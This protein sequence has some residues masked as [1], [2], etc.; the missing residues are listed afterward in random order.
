MSQIK[1]FL[2]IT[3]LVVGMAISGCGDKRDVTGFSADSGK[4]EANWLA[5]HWVDAQKNL[6]ACQECHGSNLLGGIATVS[7]FSA[8]RGAQVCHAGGPVGDNAG[9]GVGWKHQSRHGRQGAMAT[10]NQYSAGF[11]YCTKCHGADFVG[12]ADKATSCKSCHTKAPHPDKPWHGTTAGGTNHVFA[13]PKNADQCYLCHQNGNNSYLKP[14]APASAGTAPSCFNST[15]CHG[16]SAH[17]TQWTDPASS[18]FH[19]NTAAISSSCTLCH[20]VNYDGVGGT[21]PSCGNANSQTGLKCHSNGTP[22]N[23]KATDC[24]S[25][26][27]TPPNAAAFPNTQ[28]SHSAHNGLQGVTCNACH[29]GGGSGTANHAKGTPFMSIST[30]FSAKKTG[31]AIPTYTRATRNCSNVSC[32]GGNPTPAW[33]STITCEECHEQGTAKYAPEYN[34]YY[35]GHRSSKTVSL[36]ELHLKSLRNQQGTPL[37]VVAITCRNCHSEVKLTKERHFSG[38]VTHTLSPNPGLTVGGEGTLIDRYNGMKCSGIS[39]HPKVKVTDPSTEV[40]LPVDSNWDD[41]IQ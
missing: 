5:K 26:H 18:Q 39:C 2:A 20:G 11:A 14:T 15:M 7:C 4:H 27:G 1:P 9:H 24:S 16:N 32:H 35:S 30:G 22:I 25:C 31:A 37:S 38:L 41:T 10:P 40:A 19:R 23:Q 34:S 21:A 36:H 6:S 17:S 3:I 13:D 8:D 33:G 28:K 29:K 12:G